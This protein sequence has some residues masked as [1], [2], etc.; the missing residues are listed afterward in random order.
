MHP[1]Y[2]LKSTAPLTQKNMSMERASGLVVLVIGCETATLNASSFNGSGAGDL[3]TRIK[4]GSVIVVSPV[5][6]MVAASA[7]YPPS[8]SV[9]V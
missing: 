8:P 7:L 1:S 4:T 6:V 9:A 2:G 5:L 3:K